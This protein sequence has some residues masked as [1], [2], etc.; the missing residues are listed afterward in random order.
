MPADSLLKTVF[1]PLA[2]FIIMFGMGMS[3]APSDFVR[4]LRRPKAKLVGL[5]CQLLLLPL[6]ALGLVALFRLSGELAVG[7]MLISA[8]PGGA[9]SNII[10]H[11]SKGDTALSVT[12]TAVSSVVTVFSIPLIVGASLIHFMGTE[13]VIALPF[14]K[15]VLQL[16]VVILL[17][18]GLGMGAHR[19]RP[20]LTARLGK[21]FTVLSLLFLALIILA[22]VLQEEDLAGQF[23]QAGLPALLL[24]LLTMG[25]GFGVAALAGLETRQRVTLSIEAGIQNGTLALGIALGLLE[26]PAIAMPAVVYSLLMFLSGGAVIALRARSRG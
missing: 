18:I 15:T 10:S 4:V 19:V 13:T 24:N 23:R 25:L 26:N 16:A 8:C 11:L 3:L 17:P 5:S 6:T 1:L 2:L 14:G 21:P 20:A 22:A 12:L 7:L 9:T